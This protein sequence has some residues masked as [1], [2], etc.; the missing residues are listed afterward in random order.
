MVQILPQHYIVLSLFEVTWHHQSCNHKT[1]SG[2][3]GFLHVV[4]F[5]HTIHLAQL[6]L[7]LTLRFVGYEVV[8]FGSRDVICHVTIRPI[9]GGFL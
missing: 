9:V 8:P 7:S 6:S 1:R 3:G 2:V 4:H 5:N